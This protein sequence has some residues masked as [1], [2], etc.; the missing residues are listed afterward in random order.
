M[1]WGLSEGC[2]NGISGCN[3]C[4]LF[5]REVCEEGKKK[6]GMNKGI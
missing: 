2:R 5:F 4:K 1:D 6:V 3:L